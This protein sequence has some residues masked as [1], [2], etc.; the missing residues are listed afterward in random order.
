MKI[1]VFKTRDLLAKAAAR[2][3][4]SLLRAAIEKKGSATFIAA[5][6]ASQFEFLD[7]LCR[8]KGKVDWSKTT[9][10]HLDEYIGLAETHPA[11]FRRYLKQRLID[12]VNLGK[13]YL[14][15]AESDPVDECRRLNA[16][17][18]NQEIDVA[19]TGIGENGHLAFNDPPAN[20]ETQD[21]YIIVDLDERCRR[22]QLGEGWFSSFDEVPRR[23]ISMS[24][25]RICQS[26]S[27]LCVVPGQ[28][29]AEAVRNCLEKEISSLYPASVLRNHPDVHL[30]LDA[31]SA[32]LLQTIPHKP[33]A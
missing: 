1:D 28:V 9:M 11:S 14:I 3:A 6:G 10:F 33:P 26:R 20:L 5:T 12:K 27:I 16:I 2:E 30:F 29:K 8:Q 7:S 18:R 17:I 21:P 31:E 4:L 25:H 19:F 13:V 32:S 24:I 22:Q 23:A 15:N